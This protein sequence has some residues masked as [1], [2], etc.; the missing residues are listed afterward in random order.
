M[1]IACDA[2]IPADDDCTPAM[3]AGA[4]LMRLMDQLRLQA[5]AEG[6]GE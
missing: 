5:E 2:E 6:D 3:F 4:M 1:G